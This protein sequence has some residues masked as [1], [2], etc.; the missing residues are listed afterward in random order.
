MKALFDS[1]VLVSALVETHPFHIKAIKWL[2]RVKDKEISGV[3]SAHTLAE[4]YSTL[5][6]LPIYP[7]I[8][9][10]LAHNL[11]NQN[12]LPIFEFIELKVE[13]YMTVINIASQIQIT[14]GTIYDSLIAHAAHK[15]RVDKLLT[16]N[17]KH[18]KKAYPLI[19]DIVEEPH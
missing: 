7:K 1:N 2:T 11:I 14:G 18:F 6:N 19:A 17:T 8:S 13:D 9:P 5:T 10:N 15:A 16:F 12:I 4:V 3:I